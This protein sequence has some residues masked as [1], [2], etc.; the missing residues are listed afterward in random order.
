MNVSISS[1]FR[2]VLRILVLL[3]ITLSVTPAQKKTIPQ[4]VHDIWTTATGLPQNSASDIVQ[5][6]DGY[7]WFGTQEG[8]ARFDGVHFTIFDRT[9][10]PVLRD[11]WILR[12]MEDNNDGL[13]IRPQG[14]APS[15]TR[16]KKGVFRT[17][18]KADGLPSERILTWTATNDVV[19]FGTDRGLCMMKDEKFSTFSVKNGLPSDTVNGLAADRRG[20]LWVSTARGVCLLA[21]GSFRTFTTKDGY[22]DT[23]ITRINQLKSGYEDSKGTMWL[24]AP[25]HIYSFTHG[26]LS[27]YTM[28]NGAAD[29]IVNTIY[30]DK[31]GNLWF[32]TRNGLRRFDNGRFVSY[33]ASKDPDEN[34]ILEMVEDRSGDIWLVT[35][36]G[37]KRFSGDKFETYKKQDGLSNNV[38]NKIFMDREG[39]IWVGTEGG[40]IDRFHLGKFVTISAV[41]GLSDDMIQPIMQDRRGTI[42]AG[43]AGRGVNMIR[44]G[45]V[46]VIDTKNGLPANF[47]QSL[48]EDKRGAMW[49]GT[50]KGAMRIAGERRT[51]FTKKDGFKNDV[52]NAFIARKSGEFLAASANAVL[53][54]KNGTFIPYHPLDSIPTFVGYMF[55]D[56]K[57]ALW[58]GTRS[59]VYRLV[60]GTLH[61]FTPE[62]GLNGTFA[63]SIYEDAEGVIWLSMSNVGL[64][65]FKDGKFSLITPQ[66]G[67][68]DYVAYTIL[69]DQFGY[70]WMSSNRGIYR[71]SKEE[72]ND[73]ADG[74]KSS[75]KSTVYGEADGMANRECNGGYF[76]SA[77]KLTDGKLCFATV[78]GVAM[79]NPADIN[80]NPIAPPVVVES[81]SVDGTPQDLHGTVHLRAGSSK[82][83][84]HY[85]GL[86]FVGGEKVRFKYQLDGFDTYW[87]DA[88]TRRDAYY[89]NLPPGEYT[90]RVIA[91]N[92]DGVWNNEVA[93]V[94]F[95]L[96]PYFYQSSWFLAACIFL[97]LT[98]GPSIYFLRTRQLKNRTAELNAEVENR[99]RELQQT[100]DHLKD[101]QN[102]LVLSEKMASLGQLTAGIAHEIK[103]PLNFITNFAVLSQDLT[104]ELR[105]QL[106]REREQVDPER[107]A[108]IKEILDDL[109][110]NV[111]KINDHGKRADSIVRGML[112]H[113]RGKAGE[114]QQTDLNALLAEYTNLAYH[115]MRAQ[116]QSFNI[117]IETELDPTVGRVSIVPQDL[118]RAFLNIVNNAC[119]AANEKKRSQQNGFMPVVRVCTKNLGTKVEIRIRDN[120]T[121]I[122]QAVRDKIFNPFFTTKPAGIGTGL[123]LSLTYDTITQ[124]HKGEITVDTKEG[125]FTEFIIT[126]PNDHSDRGEP[127]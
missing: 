18:S 63:L 110:Q 120:G 10:T 4:Y 17:Y 52:V 60:N 87:S 117:K 81:F 121:G 6:R 84:F 85:A 16:Y 59:G 57:G 114:R 50:F 32:G 86:S 126:I 91:A 49:I 15:V 22:T 27:A 98:T 76:P 13:W 100:L 123:G 67:L 20:D 77:W 95:V 23:A 97:F 101:A 51:V 11:S 94:P 9:N 33:E 127:S 93:S 111:G 74:R 28:N 48:Y 34:N 58:I 115:G 39:S 69:E 102:Q 12:L 62:E 31:Q 36:L 1:P 88:G 113:S 37:L 38:I 53:E 106:L 42:W 124:E 5:T 47:I 112:L 79:V 2:I 122:P 105:E 75:V 45:S 82:F 107:A 92:S 65:R 83:D 3:G 29:V 54:L 26:T 116:D 44:D 7:L 103:N 73:V 41:N 19:W 40:G 43:T 25:R 119:Y 66:Q 70:F 30:E 21:G 46:T 80:L 61:H 14:F 55:E 56:S 68:F 108:E 78:K 24:A 109:E 99:T 8:L 89:T 35:G 64:Y 72:L 104:K 118:S 125:E 90:F 71:V 96:A